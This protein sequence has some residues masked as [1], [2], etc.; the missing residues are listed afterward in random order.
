M[1]EPTGGPDPA[2]R[3]RNL[4]KKIKEIAA[5]KVD[6]DAG[7]SLS[8]AQLAKIDSEASVFAEIAE[9]EKELPK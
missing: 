4:Q 5:L 3:I 6:R 9:L 1:V 8:V 2:K 7:K